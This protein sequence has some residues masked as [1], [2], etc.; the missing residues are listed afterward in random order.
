MP[1][2][3]PSPPPWKTKDYRVAGF[4]VSRGTR[5]LHTSLDARGDVEFHFDRDIANGMMD[6]YPNSD[7]CRYEMACKAMLEVVRHKRPKP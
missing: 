5:L 4:L 1:D 6:L 2:L 3:S 7:E